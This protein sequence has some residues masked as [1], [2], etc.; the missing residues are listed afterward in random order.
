MFLF[1]LQRAVFDIERW[2]SYSSVM[3]TVKMWRIQVEIFQWRIS[4]ELPNICWG[5]LKWY[6]S[7]DFHRLGWGQRVNLPHSATTNQSRG[8]ATASPRQSEREKPS[9]YG[10]LQ[11]LLWESL[12][13]CLICACM[14]IFLRHNNRLLAHPSNFLARCVYFDPGA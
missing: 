11:A 8:L 1:T 9:V 4:W 6:K 2:S 13:L 14:L 7:W 12:T 5:C 10:P 3:T